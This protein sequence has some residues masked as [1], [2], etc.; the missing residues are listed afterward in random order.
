[1]NNDCIWHE[2]FKN[3]IYSK[4]RDFFS[5]CDA[6]FII[7]VKNDK[8]I[9]NQKN[10]SKLINTLGCDNKTYWIYSKGYKKCNR[11]GQEEDIAFSTKYICN[12]ALKNNFDNILIL[13]DDCYIYGNLWEDYEN[14][15]KSVIE[16]I[17]QN[18]SNPLIFHF[19]YAPIYYKNI[20]KY[21]RKGSFTNAHCVMY[22]KELCKKFINIYDTILKL[23]LHIDKYYIFDNF[24]VKNY[25]LRPNNLFFQENP[26]KARHFLYKILNFVQKQFTGREY[27]QYDPLFVPYH[28]FFLNYYTIKFKLFFVIFLFYLFF[29]CQIKI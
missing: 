1:M 5:F 6:V 29:K 21:I 9:N 10:M 11:K 27:Y 8:Y 20:N 18:N 25:A 7:T 3:N 16:V 12:F 15:R 19:G 22:N 28:E 4:Q 14:K 26:K 2:K 24:G 23:N 13:E 17:K